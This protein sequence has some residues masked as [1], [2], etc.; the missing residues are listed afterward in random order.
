MSGSDPKY[1]KSKFLSRAPLENSNAKWTR[2][3]LTTY[4]DPNGV[5]RTWESAERRTRPPGCEVDGVGIVT[6]IDKPTGPE[7]LLQKQYRP[8]ID[9]VVIEV[10]AGLIDAGET[11]EECAVRELREETGYVG[12]AEQTSTLMFNDPG[13]CN[14]NLNMVHVRVDLS[15][16]ENQDPKPQLEDN[17]FIECFTLPLST[18]F[19]ELKR[20]EAE[21]YAIDARV[22]TLAEGIE[23]AQ[24]L[25]L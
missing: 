2:L 18:L 17:E 13:M 24:K 10:P 6:I 11:V 14:T 3:V 7:L 8:P 20:L 22:G 1:A 9:K 16:P 12:V 19:S 25:K 5:E 4:T 21:G 23:L 15:L